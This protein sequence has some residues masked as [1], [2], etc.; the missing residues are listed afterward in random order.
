MNTLIPFLL[1]P[2]LVDRSYE[3]IKMDVLETRGTVSPTCILNR[4]AAPGTF[5]SCSETDTSLG[6]K[7]QRKGG[8]SLRNDC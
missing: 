3:M 1:T 5:P 2:Q 8:I 4:H 7:S 6:I